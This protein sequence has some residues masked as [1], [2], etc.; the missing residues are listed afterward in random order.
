MGREEAVVPIDVLEQEAV[1]DG[2]F[3]VY[4][5]WKEATPEYCDASTDPDLGSSSESLDTGSSNSSG[6]G[7][8]QVA[9]ED[10]TR[11]IPRKLEAQFEAASEGDNQQDPPNDA[12]LVALVTLRVDGLA[13][14][15]A[16][17]AVRDGIV[18]SCCSE[19]ATQPFHI[20]RLQVVCSS[21]FPGEEVAVFGAD[22]H[23]GRWDIAQAVRM[24]T[25]RATYPVW[26]CELSPPN[27]GS[28]F[29]LAIISLTGW[30]SL[31]GNRTWPS[32]TCTCLN[33]TFGQSGSAWVSRLGFF[34][35]EGS[36]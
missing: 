34:P 4:D 5:A 1:G 36:A 14:D 9:C 29:K 8:A 22:P 10:Q 33:L 25:D 15:A 30:E 21:T 7:A 19:S 3:F 32:D 31:I 16:D 12:G 27:T 13:E 26:S 11:S 20:C 23:L 28:E 18:D 24:T 35:Q 2:K 6:E 17:D